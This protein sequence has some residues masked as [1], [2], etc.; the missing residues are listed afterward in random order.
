MEGWVMRVGE[1]VREANRMVAFGRV[2]FAGY[3]GCVCFMTL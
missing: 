3:N 2:G 1:S